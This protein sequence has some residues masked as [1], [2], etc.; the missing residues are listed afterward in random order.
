MLFAEE[1]KMYTHIKIG[2]SETGN[3]PLPAFI[4]RTLRTSHV[5]SLH[6]LRHEDSWHSLRADVAVAEL[7]LFM[8]SR[9]HACILYVSIW[10]NRTFLYDANAAPNPRRLYRRAECTCAHVQYTKHTEQRTGG[11]KRRNKGNIGTKKMKR[12]RERE[13]RKDEKRHEHWA[14]VQHR[15]CH[16]LRCSPRVYV[17]PSTTLRVNT[18]TSPRTRRCITRNAK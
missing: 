16:E 9:P 2:R 1:K 12:E 3:E 11:R 7:L 8:L 14:Q 4:L 13:I 6:R 15:A 5:L 18:Y 10:I 17:A